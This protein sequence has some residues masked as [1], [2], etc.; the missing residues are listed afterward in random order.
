MRT[1]EC[2]RCATLQIRLQRR[3]ITALLV[4]DCGGCSQTVPE[5]RFSA[6]SE[7]CR[8]SFK[9][10]LFSVRFVA[11]VNAMPAAAEGGPPCR[12]RAADCGDACPKAYSGA[13]RSRETMRLQPVFFDS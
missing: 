3:P 10:Q 11:N 13:C 1:H 7:A 8:L 5:M 4:A 12:P 2:G 6:C 9:K